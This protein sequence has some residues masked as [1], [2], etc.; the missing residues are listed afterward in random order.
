[1]QL[2]STKDT[3]EAYKKTPIAN[4]EKDN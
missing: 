4:L 3:E 2:S 1:L